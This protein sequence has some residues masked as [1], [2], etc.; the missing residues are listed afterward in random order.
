MQTVAAVEACCVRRALRRAPH[1]TP[2]TGACVWPTYGASGESFDQRRIKGPLPKGRL[3]QSAGARR[4][5]AVTHRAR[6]AGYKPATAE[7]IIRVLFTFS[8]M[9][10]GDRQV[11]GVPRRPHFFEV[12]QAGDD[13]AGKNL[14][15]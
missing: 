13:P 7:D 15:R 3:G 1:G 5:N 10:R 9:D 4:D 6:D 2:G 14:A 8:H 12:W 11:S